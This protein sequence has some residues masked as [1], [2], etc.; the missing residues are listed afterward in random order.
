VRDDGGAPMKFG[1][2]AEIDGE[3]QL[4]VLALAQAQVGGLN[5]HPG[6]A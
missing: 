1:D 4:H 6:G 5:E 3:H 2:C